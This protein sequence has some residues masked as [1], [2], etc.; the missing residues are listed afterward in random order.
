MASLRGKVRY[1]SDDQLTWTRKRVGKSFQYLNE[2]GKP[3]KTADEERVKHL[4]IPPAWKQVRISPDE[5]GH[6]Q[7]VG[8]DDKER[9]QYIYH[10]VWSE[11]KQQQKF[12][13]VV[14]FGEVLPTLRQTIAGH[15]R[16]RELT[17]ERILSTIVY[18]LEHTFIRVGNK[19][20]A[21]ENQSF[22]LTTL[23]EKH[24]ELD[25]NVVT[26]KF[27][28]KSGVHHEYNLR[29]PKIVRTVRQCLEL[30]GYNLFQY[31]D[32]DDERQVVDSSDVNEYLQAI[33]GEEF[34]AKDFRTW[35]GTTL[36]GDTLF[37][38]GPPVDESALKKA[39][40]QTVEE[41]SSHLHN[42]EAV[43]RKYY[44]HPAIFTSYEKAMLVPHYEKSYASIKDR[45]GLTP[46][47]YASWSLISKLS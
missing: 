12:D 5:K 18:L 35:G 39:L 31:L 27:K 46:L 9:K 36:A 33:T 29:D 11:V 3:L 38:I 23:R 41:V 34:S 2:K 1:I 6:I 20:Y 24:V 43:C 25:G 7:A 26:L 8:F 30:P 32:E 28:G 45:S 37:K 16:Q 47:E 44:I 17:R 4:G 13:K 19:E 15:M 40:I 21:E 42:T 10:P 14:K 22:G